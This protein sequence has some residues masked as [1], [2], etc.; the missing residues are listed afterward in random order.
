MIRWP[1]V[2]TR[3]LRAVLAGVLAYLNMIPSLIVIFNPLLFI[4]FL[5]LGVYFFL[6]WPWA[7]LRYLPDPF[8]P[9]ESLYWLTYA[10]QFGDTPIFP[11]IF[12][13]GILDS[14]LTFIGSAIFISSFLTWLRGLKG[15]LVTYG[16]YGAVRHPQYLGI[17]L[18]SLGLSVRSLRP[19]SF[20]AWLTLLF[21]YL[22]LASLEERS[23][24]RTYGERYERYCG[25]VPFMI[26]LFNLRVPQWLSPRGPYRYILLLTVYIFLTF[27]MM[28]C[29]RSFVFSLRITFQGIESSLP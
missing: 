20:I 15:G 5:P 24:L 7:W 29:L 18:L 13:W 12:R 21:G 11:S 19:A 6:T 27:M 10:V 17:I 26:P 28:I 1:P 3:V 22:T 14:A 8:H 9:G 16:F 25:E 2:V 23:L 4:M